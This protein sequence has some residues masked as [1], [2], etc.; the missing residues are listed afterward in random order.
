MYIAFNNTWR[1][2]QMK[3]CNKFHLLACKQHVFFASKY[4]LNLQVFLL[5]FFLF[6][7]KMVEIVGKLRNRPVPILLTNDMLQAMDLL[8]ASREACGVMS[9]YFLPFLGLHLG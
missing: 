8:V 6:S 5:L 3:N 2:I 4:G 7:M 1:A 9:D